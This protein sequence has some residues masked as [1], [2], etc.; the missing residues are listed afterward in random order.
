[1][2]FR[3]FQAFIPLSSIVIHIRGENP[4]QGQEIAPNSAWCT[5]YP[6]PHLR[7][8]APDRGFSTLYIG[9]TVLRIKFWEKFSFFQEG[10]GLFLSMGIFKKNF[11]KK[12]S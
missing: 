9:H 4:P 11:P 6:T 5:P 1:V 2:L 8:P 10:G 7:N 3:P 12:I